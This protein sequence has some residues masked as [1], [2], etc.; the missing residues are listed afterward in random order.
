MSSERNAVEK[1]VEE[2]LIDLMEDKVFST[3]AHA[4]STRGLQASP[5]TARRSRPSR[6]VTKKQSKHRDDL[7][8]TKLIPSI[9]P[10]YIPPLAGVVSRDNIPRDFNYTL[11]TVYLLKGIH[12]VGSYLGQILMLKINDLNLG[13]HKNYGMLTPRK[14]LTKTMGNKLNIIPQPWTMDIAISTILNVMKIPHFSRHQEVNTCIKL[15]LSCYHGVYLWL[16]RHITVDLTLIHQIT[17]LS[18]QGSNPQDFYPGKVADR[19]LAQY[20]KYTYDDVEKGKRGYKIASIQ[21]G[22]VRLAF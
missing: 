16:D 10:D 4:S 9:L 3:G 7:E 5:S 2:I 14:S 18:M 1:S 12:T 17:K 15:L 6:T 8:N 20:I 13:Y 21:N 11:I 22:E 19:A